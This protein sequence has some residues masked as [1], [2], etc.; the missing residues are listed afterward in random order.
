MRKE[1]L[2]EHWEEALEWKGGEGKYACGFIEG[3]S[4]GGLNG[5]MGNFCIDADGVEARLLYTIVHKV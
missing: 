3:R 2:F 5:P 1:G 4:G